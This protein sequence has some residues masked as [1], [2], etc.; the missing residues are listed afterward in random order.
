MERDDQATVNAATTTENDLTA[1]ETDDSVFTPIAASTP[2]TADGVAV[3]TCS[4]VIPVHN[5]ASLTR[6]CLNVLLAQPASAAVKREVIVVDDGST[7]LT[8]R[9]LAGYGDRIRVITHTKGRGF[10]EA[11]QAGAAVASGEY[12]V[13]LNND[14]VP[15]ADWLSALAA[16]AEA[17]PAAAVVGAKLLYPNDTIQH[18]GVVFGQDRY[19]H[20]LYIGFP[21]DHPAANVSRRFQVVTGACCLIRRDAW[22]AM[23]GFD[24]GFVNGWEDV[25]LCLRLGEAGHEIHYCHESVVYHLESSSRDLRAP[26][27]RANR[28]RFRERWREKIEPDDV[29]YW[30]ADG[31]LAITYAARHPFQL[32][33]SPLLAGVTV[34]EAERLGDRLLAERA[35]QVA[36][37]LRNSLVLNTRVQE[38]ELRTQHAEIRAR[39]AEQRL[40]ETEGRLAA[41]GGDGS[42]GAISGNGAGPVVE[43]PL[44]SAPLPG[45]A[46]GSEAAAAALTAGPTAPAPSEPP[47]PYPILGMVERPSRLPE[48]V[49]EEILV[50]S[51]WVLSRAGIFRVEALIDGEV[52]GNVQF[53]LPRPDAA[54]LHP[55][56]PD[57]EE[58]GFFGA[59]P[60]ED[61]EDSAHSL[62]L[63]VTAKDGRQAEIGTKFEVDSTARAKGKVL[64]R[65]DRPL[66]GSVT[67]VRDRLLVAGWAVSPHG[68]R[69][70]EALVDGE[71]RGPLADGALR[72]DIGISY[73]SYPDA[74]HS[75]FGGSVALAGVADGEHRLVLRITAKNDVE[76]ELEAPFI[77]DASAP[78]LGEV[79]KIN[80]QYPEW[81][82]KH[83]PDA[84][85]L[86]RARD[87]AVALVGQPVV[88]LIVPLGLAE[89]EALVATVESVQA[90]VS[91]AWQLCLAAG[92]DTPAATRH[93]AGHLA[94]GDGRILLAGE[95]PN[96]EDGL[97]GE[98]NA[99][100]VLADGDWV[101]L[102]PPGDLLSPVALLEVAKWLADRP[103]T[104]LLYVDEDKHDPLTGLRWDPFFKPDWSPDL[105]LSTSYLG[106]FV[107]MRR[108]VVERLGGFRA[109]FAGA[110]WDDLLLRATDEAPVVGHI[111]RLLASRQADAGLSPADTVDGRRLEARRRA[112]AAALARRGLAATVEPGVAPAALRV[113]PTLPTEA[114]GVTIVM[115]T[116]GKLQ[117]LRPCLEDLLTRTT[118]PNLHLLLIDNSDGDAVEALCEEM[119]GRGL[120]LRRER[121]QIQPFNFSALI[122]HAIPFVETPYLILLNDDVTVLTPD[123]VESLLEHAQRPEIGV[124]GPKLLYPDGTIQHAG[125]I[126]GP[127]Q[128]T[129]HAFVRFPGDTAGQFGLPNATREYSAVTF[130]CAM[131][132]REL[133]DEVGPLDAA[134]LPIAFNDTEFCLRVGAAG[135]KVLYTPH[136]VLTH[137]ESVTKKV[138]AQPSEIGYLRTHWGHVIAH[139]PSYNPNLTRRSE[140]CSLNMD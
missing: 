51:G 42:G 97:A 87:E 103:E 66:P 4:I 98:A 93:L 109:D 82:G 39:A 5:R 105:A 18:A 137:H 34:G 3:V 13:L 74:N 92:T 79:P 115:P 126:L 77:V 72:P 78:E 48:I 118:Y 38:A 116:G 63:R 71:P 58:C 88:S 30:L 70:I 89:A 124:V 52:R 69:S 134:R 14:T 131:L 108:R 7:D 49:T 17:H 94:E 16:Y 121:F 136:A 41:L 102:L 81:R 57:G 122:N 65:I 106:G 127:F 36:I 12:L 10:A 56:F 54:A 138:I 128:G 80:A 64:A 76:I 45:A 60:V 140:D 6:Q 75:G 120:R 100:L 68:I 99:A 47:T 84:E 19:P 23:G 117:F 104:E 37:L 35:K 21:A 90:Q 123:W 25:D 139:D 107:P 119:M 26:Q 114:P 125:V 67:T 9:L 11:C 44:A 61:L 27:E 132:R 24:T 28:E 96:A 86:A 112:V 110:E 135:Y 113:R 15:R 22:D 133:F 129:C 29:Q 130:A 62:L 91:D 111:P 83:E 31:L 2:K 8:G 73:P 50:V 55:G 1:P 85:A 33:V 95:E 59:V 53:G 32:T 40:T 46:G 101:A 43:L 20:H